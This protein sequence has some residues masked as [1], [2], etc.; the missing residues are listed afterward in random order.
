M[1]RIPKKLTVI[2][3]GLLFSLLAGTTTAEVVVVVSTQNPVQALSRSELADIYL[4]RRNRFPNDEPAVPIDHREGSPIHNEFYAEYLNQ[5][6]AQVK[7][8]WSKLIFTGRGQPPR[9]VPDGDAM[10][11]T[12]AKSPHAIGYIDPDLVNDQL[13]I[14]QID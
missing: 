7:A 2:G 6:P 8:H 10:A 3:C 13:R 4:G 9:A 14:V 1:V 11:E 12:V 5:T